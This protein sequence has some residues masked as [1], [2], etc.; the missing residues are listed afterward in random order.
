MTYIIDY[1]QLWPKIV[2]NDATSIEQF[3]K[4]DLFQDIY[5]KY[6]SDFSIVNPWLKLRTMFPPLTS[7][8]L[9]R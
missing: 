4:G 1:E 6:C 2:A 8:N 9:C 3:S 5:Q 7:S